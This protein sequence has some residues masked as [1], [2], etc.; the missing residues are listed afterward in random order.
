MLLDM[1]SWNCIVCSDGGYP[2]SSLE[3]KCKIHG[4][5]WVRKP[6]QDSLCGLEEFTASLT[7]APSS[8]KWG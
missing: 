2:H 8:I 7:S 4:S 1:G 6:G 3:R 5:L